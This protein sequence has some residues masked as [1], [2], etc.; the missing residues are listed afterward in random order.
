MKKILNISLLA[1]AFFCISYPFLFG[2]YPFNFKNECK[3][4]ISDSVF[5]DKKIECI[6]L[7]RREYGDED[8]KRINNFNP[9][10]IL[11]LKSGD[12]IFKIDTKNFGNYYE[13]MKAEIGETIVIKG[14]TIKRKRIEGD[15]GKVI[16]KYRKECPEEFILVIKFPDTLIN[17]NNKKMYYDWGVGG[18]IFRTEK[19]ELKN[20]DVLYKI[21][22]NKENGR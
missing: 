7:N 4:C 5:K 8:R 2:L 17:I 15:W 16:D 14:N 21:I 10:Y 22:K 12:S 11:T 13:A 18:E 19:G 1:L 9:T 6:L 20:T 3:E